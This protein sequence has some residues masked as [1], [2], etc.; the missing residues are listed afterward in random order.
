MTFKIGIDIGGTHTDAVVVDENGTLIANTKTRTTANISEG[1]RIAL[2]NLSCP[3]VKEVRIGTTHATNA[4]LEAKNLLKV[5]IIRLTGKRE[6]LIP[7]AFDWPPALAAHVVKTVAVEGGF[8]CD[9]RE[10]APLNLQEVDTAIASLIDAGAEGIVIVSCFSP[11][12]AEHENLV[13]QRISLPVCCSSEVSGL[14]FIERENTALLNLMLRNVL[15][16]G[17][18][19]LQ[20]DVP[21]FLTHNEGSLM[22]LKEAIEKPILTLSS[23]QTN[24][25]IGAAKL[26]GL[27]DAVVIDIGG[28]TTDIGVVQNG[29]PRKTLGSVDIGGIPL[30]FP[31]PDVLSIALGGGSVVAG[32]SVG[33][34]SVGK[35]LFQQATC[36]GGTVLTLTCL[37][38]RAGALHIEGSNPTLVPLSLDDAKRLHRNA[39]DSILHLAKTMQASTKNFPILAVGGGSLLFETLFEQEGIFQLKHGTIANAFGAAL[40]EIAATIDTVVTVDQV[41]Q[42]KLRA[43]EKVVEKGA[44]PE[45]V[46]LT[47]LDIIPYHYLGGNRARVVVTAAGQH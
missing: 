38:I 24:S 22:N 37:A 40:T 3:N 8:E 12:F 20:L 2:Q 35:E 11:L 6:P 17:F 1:V 34:T 25:F 33:P 47:H 44:R 23:G 7:A 46:R 5:G 31:M 30:N 45:T 26:A 36:F 29:F 28:T 43:I 19:D 15:R 39:F 14:G 10:R 42:L 27:L 13:R 21:L 9:G 4:L 32:N 41:E 18:A 16:K